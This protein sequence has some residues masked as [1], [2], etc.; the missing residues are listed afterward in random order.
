MVALGVPQASGQAG[1]VTPEKLAYGKHL[2]QECTTCHRAD[3]RSAN[4]PPIVGL[5]PDYFIT[6]LK[7][8]KSGA[9][10]NPVMKSVAGPLNEEQIEALAAYLAT[11]KPPAK[12]APA[13]RKK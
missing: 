11:Q 13:G 9:R 2:A 4:I 7:F 3:S 12:Q 10:D 1:V 5:E 6:T 8:Y